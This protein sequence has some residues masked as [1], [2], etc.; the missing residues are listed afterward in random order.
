[1]VV[2][3]CIDMLECIGMLECIDMQECIH[4]LECID[5]LECKYLP[6]CIHMLECKYLSECIHMLECIDMPGGL[7]RRRTTSARVT[8]HA[9]TVF[10]GWNMDSIHAA[11]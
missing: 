3:E 6:E 8:K 5:M 2:R 11:S 10:S 9:Q 7:P 1:M 4:M